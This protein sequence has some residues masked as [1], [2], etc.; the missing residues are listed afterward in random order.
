MIFSRF[1][2]A[3]LCAAVLSA[4]SSVPRVISEYRIDVQQGN[5]VSQEMVSQL[6]SG[7]TKEQVRFLLGTP[8]LID[9][10][11]TDRWDYVYRLQKGAS[12]EAETRR[13]SVF[14]DGDG[15]LARVSGDVVAASATPAAET[16]PTPAAQVL[17]L[18]S[19]NEDG[20]APPPLDD[21]KGFFTKLKESVGL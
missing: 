16:S 14:F 1:A 9:I 18:G 5:V 17:D 3:A 10:F 19:L 8:L 4:C 11:H 15:K 12:R 6:R 2:G 13:F 7:L 21:E 20:S